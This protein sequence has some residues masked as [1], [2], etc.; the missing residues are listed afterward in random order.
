MKR[1]LLGLNFKQGLEDILEDAYL[2]AYEFD[3]EIVPVHVIEDLPF[4]NKVRESKLLHDRIQVHLDKVR[5]NLFLRE[6][7]V[8]DPGNLMGNSFDSL[9]KGCQTMNGDLLLIGS[10][11]NDDASY[12]LGRSAKKILRQAKVPVWVSNPKSPLE[13]FDQM[14]CAVDFSYHSKKTLETAI[15]L[16]DSLNAKLKVIYVAQELSLYPGLTISQDVYVSNWGSHVY[17]IPVESKAQLAK[18]E[19]RLKAKDIEE[20]DEFLQGVDFRHVEVEK[21]ILYG[22]AYR[23]ILE[24]ME[25]S[26]AGLLVVGS[27]GRGGF[28]ERML[29]GT[30]E[31][32]LDR[33]NCTV[34]VVT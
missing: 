30:I 8:A 24:A 20:M 33:L 27:H 21:E 11:N 1:I 4:Y 19:A 15:I 6:I 26:P 9:R 12:N 3:A 22:Y 32:I 25:N 23:E 10:G 18:E 17:S 14:I 2:L 16:A 13:S 34:L 5:E 28:I 31:K 7:K 29:G